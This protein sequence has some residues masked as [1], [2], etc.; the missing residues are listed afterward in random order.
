VLLINE[1]PNQV[2]RERK[3][4]GMHWCR[5]CPSFYPL[6]SCPNVRLSD[7]ERARGYN[8]LVSKVI[9]GDLHSFA[10]KFRYIDP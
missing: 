6:V 4:V 1:K 3:K 2:V 8:V 7:T 5:E 9:M 10:G